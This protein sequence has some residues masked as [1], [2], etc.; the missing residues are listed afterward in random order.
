MD[1]Y[2]LPLPGFADRPQAQMRRD[3]VIE[4]RPILAFDALEAALAMPGMQREL[5]VRGGGIGAAGAFLWTLQP[6]SCGRSNKTA[7][8]SMHS[9]RSPGAKGNMRREKFRSSFRCSLSQSE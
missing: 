9:S 4:L 8:S 3:P 7:T 1:R 6:H 5:L 2:S